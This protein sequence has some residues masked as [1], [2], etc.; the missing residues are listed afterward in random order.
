MFA[1]GTAT[2][3]PDARALLAAVAGRL[4]RDGARL[5]IEGHTDASGGNGDANWVLS[6][7]R[8]QAARR[9]LTE[10]GVS[11]QRIAEVTGVAANKSATPDDPGRPENRRISLRLLAEPPAMPAELGLARRK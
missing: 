7:E 4:G 5:A 6:A 9:V 11:V 3:T 8:A 10:N 1:S 2:L